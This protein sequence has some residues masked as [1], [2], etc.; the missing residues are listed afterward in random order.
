MYMHKTITTAEKIAEIY[1]EIGMRR[2]VWGKT[3]EFSPVATRRILIMQ[4]IATDYETQAKR[5]ELP[6]DR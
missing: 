4:S 5:E 3:G 1:K 2:R 6:L